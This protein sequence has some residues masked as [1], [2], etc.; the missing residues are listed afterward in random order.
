MHKFG[1]VFKSIWKGI[2]WDYNWVINF[3]YSGTLRFYVKLAASDLKKGMCVWK[4]IL[5][6]KNICWCNKKYCL[7][8]KAFLWPPHHQNDIS[9]W[10]ME[11]EAKSTS[12]PI[13]AALHP[14]TLSW[15]GSHL[16][17]LNPGR[18]ATVVPRTS[19]TSYELLGRYIEPT[20]KSALSQLECYHCLR[21]VGESQVTQSYGDCN[22]TS[23]SPIQRDPPSIC[24]RVWLF[25]DCPL[26]ESS[27]EADGTGE[28]KWQAIVPGAA[29]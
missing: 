23:W 21:R 27:C 14:N 15:A 3:P 10:G 16:A 5:L 25:H 19:A 9:T 29:C 18:R 2:G 13:E 28:C 26:K 22:Q 12:C 1:I 4:C 20:L 11:T 6:S 7:S 17:N 8:L 24:G